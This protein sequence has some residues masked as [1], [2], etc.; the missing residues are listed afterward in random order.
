MVSNQYVELAWESLRGTLGIDAGKVPI[1]VPNAFYKILKT[2][3]EE[4]F[5]DAWDHYVAEKY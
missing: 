2:T 5:S 3:Y 1:E 4:G